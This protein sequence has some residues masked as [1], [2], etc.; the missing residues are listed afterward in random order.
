MWL[1]HSQF[2]IVFQLSKS[3]TQSPYAMAYKIL[4]YL[5][6]F[7]LV[8]DLVFYQS[9]FPLLC[10][11]YI[12]IFSVF[13]THKVSKKLCNKLG[14]YFLSCT[15]GLHPSLLLLLQQILFSQ[16]A[17]PTTLAYTFF[18]NFE[19]SYPLIFFH[20]THPELIYYIILFMF[21]VND[22]FPNSPINY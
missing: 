13:Q 18:S 10:S 21:L 6:P 1:F 3:K 19:F 14:K 2:W 5:P 12:D 8:F 17:F 9:L 20:S 15:Y 16:K 4:Y 7:L 22:L 11:T